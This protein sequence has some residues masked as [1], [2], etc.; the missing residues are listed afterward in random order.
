MF[1]NITL[2]LADVIEDTIVRGCRGAEQRQVRRHLPK[3][4]DEAAVV[5]AKVVPPIRDAVRLI[6]DK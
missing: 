2:V 1:D 4:V 3:H 6:D 5:R